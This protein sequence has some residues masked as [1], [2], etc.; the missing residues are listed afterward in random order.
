[1]RVA[2]GDVKYKEIADATGISAPSIT[3]YFKGEIPKSTQLA[4]LADYFGVTMDFLYRGAEETFKEQGGPY[5]EA[6][7]TWRR[8]AMAAEQRLL[9]LRQRLRDALNASSETPVPAAGEYEQRG[10]AIVKTTGEERAAEKKLLQS[11]L[12]PDAPLKERKK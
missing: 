9:D 1:L 6:T 12:Q 10:K 7:E 11:A 5:G 3:N 4:A 2:R 8:R